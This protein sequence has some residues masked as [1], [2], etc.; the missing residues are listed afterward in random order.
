M[1]CFEILGRELLLNVNDKEAERQ[2]NA[3]EIPNCPGSIP[4]EVWGVMVKC[5]AKIPKDRPP[6]SDVIVYFQEIRARTSSPSVLLDISFT[7][8]YTLSSLLLQIFATIYLGWLHW[9]R[10]I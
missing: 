3:G 9:R 8:I 7:V 6:I 5:W 4:S 2:L 1:L 10:P